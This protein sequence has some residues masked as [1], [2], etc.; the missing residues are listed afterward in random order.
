MYLD[1]EIREFINKKYS[2]ID[3]ETEMCF[4][5]DEVVELISEFVEAL[6]KK[7]ESKCEHLLFTKPFLFKEKLAVDEFN[8]N[9][10][11]ESDR[12]V[13][14]ENDDVRFCFDKKVIRVL[15]YDGSNKELKRRIQ[16]YFYE[17]QWKQ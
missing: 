13:I 8:L 11:F 5:E 3:D 4:T 14:Y 2:R 15:L 1:K 12:T 9:F 6:D 7:E 10:V 17:K 16:D